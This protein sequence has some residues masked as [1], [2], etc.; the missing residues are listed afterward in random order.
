MS[1]MRLYETLKYWLELSFF[2]MS[3]SSVGA[4][5]GPVALPELTG[6]DEPMVDDDVGADA[7]EAPM[8][9]TSRCTSGTK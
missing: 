8:D 1:F 2:L 7:D 6:A 4:A 5:A 9:G 3:A